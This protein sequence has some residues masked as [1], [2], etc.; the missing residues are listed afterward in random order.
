MQVPPDEVLVGD[1]ILVKAG[2]K[3][4]L[5]GRV[6]GSASLDTSALTGESAPY[7]V[8]EGGGCWQAR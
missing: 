7:D 6:K 2:E 3:V 1:I 8:G 4:P 5:D